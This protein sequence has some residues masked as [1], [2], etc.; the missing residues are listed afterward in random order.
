MAH[1][2]GG[3]R[4]LELE[5]LETRIVQSATTAHAAETPIDALA[6]GLVLK[7]PTPQV[8]IHQDVT[9]IATDASSTTGRPI[10]AGKIEFLIDSP[11]PVVLGESKLNKTGATS[12]ATNKLTKVGTYWIIA[13]YVE[14]GGKIDPSETSTPLAIDVTPLGTTSFRVTPAVKFGRIGE[15]ISFTVTALNSAGQPVT[16][17]TG[18]V[19]ITSPTDSA[20]TFGKHFYI[21][22]QL[23]PPIP[24]TLGLAS[25]QNQTYQFQ[26]SD[27]GSHTF[28]DGVTFG[29]G[30]AEEV[31]ATQANNA[32]IH[33]K[34]VIAIS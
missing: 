15:P 16:N 2:Q 25:F 1:R 13:R 27:H 30:G 5:P 32:N 11:N 23:P 34:G 8:Q 20:T 6:R 19:H 31:K 29:K 7:T 14:P 10:R 28:T 18:T 21:N 22:L 9:F 3:R 24:W 12:F 26:P 33:G 4:M 17:Y